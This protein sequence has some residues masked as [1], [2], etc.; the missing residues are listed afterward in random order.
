MVNFTQ[1][2]LILLYLSEVRW[3]WEHK[4]LI[5]E[6]MK[7]RSVTECLLLFGPEWNILPLAG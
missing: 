3:E 1:N 5:Y 6:E 2:L 7:K 4:H